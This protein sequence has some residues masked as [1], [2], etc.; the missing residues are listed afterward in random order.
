MAKFHSSKISAQLQLFHLKAR[1]SSG[2]GKSHCG[3]LI[4]KW[5]VQ[6]TPLSRIYQARLE[7]DNYGK[8]SVYIDSPDIKLLASGK[9]LPHVY[10]QD[11]KKLC[12]YLPGSGQWNNNLFLADT[13]VPWTSLWLMYFEEWVWSGEWQGG[14][15]HPDVSTKEKK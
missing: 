10:D 15:E 14:G 13:V 8:P 4:W 6:P 1:D 12:L 11:K 2:V 7:C 5:S 3:R 9:H